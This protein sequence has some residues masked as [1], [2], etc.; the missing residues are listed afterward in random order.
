MT[1]DT[2]AI[3][4]TIVAATPTLGGLLPAE[5]PPRVT[6]K[7]RRVDRDHDEGHEGDHRHDRRSDA[8]VGRPAAR[9]TT[10]ARHGE[11]NSQL[12]TRRTA[13]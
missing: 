12:N 10:A 11:Q 1:K 2:K 4:G 6:V 5:Q 3:I 7:E 8:H 13:S 9:R